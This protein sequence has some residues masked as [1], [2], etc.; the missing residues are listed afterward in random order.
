MQ[1]LQ[2]ILPPWKEHKLFINVNKTDKGK[3]QGY[4]ENH[5]CA[6]FRILSQIHRQGERKKIT[7]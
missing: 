3:N 5:V 7:N 1:R 4:N 6:I 2:Y